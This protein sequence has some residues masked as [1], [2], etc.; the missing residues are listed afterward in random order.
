MKN[1]WKLLFSG[2]VVISLFGAQVVT[3]IFAPHLH[4]ADSSTQD[5]WT[6]LSTAGIEAYRRGS[7]VEA[8]TAWKKALKVA[9]Q[10]KQEA[11]QAVI[12]HDLADCYYKQR[13]YKEAEQMFKLALAI[14]ERVLGPSSADLARTLHDYAVLLKHT[15]RQTEAEKLETRIHKIQS[16]NRWVPRTFPPDIIGPGVIQK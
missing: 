16:R 3:V 10:S 14:R 2:I 5:V 7:Y 6:E 13:R 12:Y 1:A 15:N 8:E 9:Q 4:A 11:R